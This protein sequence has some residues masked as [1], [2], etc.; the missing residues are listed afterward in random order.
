MKKLKNPAQNMENVMDLMGIV[1]VL[2]DT[3]MVCTGM[4]CIM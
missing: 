3:I 2:T 1:L 4:W